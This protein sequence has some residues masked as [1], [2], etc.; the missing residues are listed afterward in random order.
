MNQKQIRCPTCLRDFDYHGTNNLPEHNRVILPV[1][2]AGS[3]TDGDV[4]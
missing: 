1:R 3:G 4:L 2:C